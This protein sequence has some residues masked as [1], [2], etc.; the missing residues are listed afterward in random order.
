MRG[1]TK[2]VP[3]AWE[4]RPRRATRARSPLPGHVLL[5]VVG[6]RNLR[7]RPPH[8][9]RRVRHG[10]AGD[11][12]PRGLGRRRC[13]R[14]RSRRPVARRS[15]SS[16]RRTSRPAEPASSASPGGPTSASTG[17]RSERTWTG[18]SRRGCTCPR[19]AFIGFRTGSTAMPPRSPSRSRAFAILC[20]TDRRS[21][22]MTTCSSSARAR[23]GS[24]PPR[25]RARREDGS[26]CAGRRAT[27]VR[28]A[29][30]EELRFE[31][32]FEGEC[33]D[34]RRRRRLLGRR[35]GYRPRPR[36]EPGVE[37]AMSRSGSP[38]SPSRFRS[39]SSASRS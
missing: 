33:P 39:T 5:A 20:S 23:S 35:F 6:S 16:A 29:K 28:L 17:A 9:R 2:L 24:S 19:R 15:R 34:G 10:D 38:A 37:V 4:P 7:Y 14:E 22:R 21:P 30:A 13:A 26:T 31:T 12:R 8:R 11:D 1:L 32:T 27:T 36:G 25:S 3:G 18:R